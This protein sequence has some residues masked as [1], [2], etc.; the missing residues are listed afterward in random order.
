V[1]SWFRT[2]VVPEITC[3]RA[4]TPTARA[5]KSSSSGGVVLIATGTSGSVAKVSISRLVAEEPIV[6]L[7]GEGDLATEGARP[8]TDCGEEL[9][10]TAS[11]C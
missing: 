10:G 2:G 4:E 1:G 3:C 5:L 9:D 6:R 11:G 7:I 8:I